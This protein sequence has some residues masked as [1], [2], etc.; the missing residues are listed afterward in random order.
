MPPPKAKQTRRKRSGPWF[1]SPPP[2]WPL[3]DLNVLREVDGDTAV[4]LLLALYN[5]RLLADSP[6]ELRGNLFRAPAEVTINE[7][8]P[9]RLR[10]P[11]RLFSQL[12]R[13]PTRVRDR[14]M[15]AA[16]RAV[17]EWAEDHSHRVT[18]I[19]FA[20]AAARLLP[21]D[22]ELANLAGR[23][24]RR[25]GDRPRAELWY[26]RGWGLARKSGDI[27]QY[28]DGHLG[29]GGLLRDFGEY[30]RALKKIKRAGLSARKKGMRESA[31]EALHD[32][33]YLAYLREDLS[34]AAS[35]AL[36]A[37]KVY[38]IHARRRPYYTADL[39]LL[40]TR[41]GLYAEALDLLRLALTHLHAP[42][43][44]LH[45]FALIA[46]AAGGARDYDAFALALREVQDSAS[47]HPE[48]G[49]AAL[50][51]AAAGA[52]LMEDWT[53][54][55]SLISESIERTRGDVTASALAERVAADIAVR[56]PGIGR[57]A[58][59]EAFVPALLGIVPE[60][61]ARLRR[62]RGATWRPPRR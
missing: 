21:E 1:V 31:A 19:G 40:L 12:V 7:S 45:V 34:R 48:V 56:R 38:P 51:Y 17:A 22:A 24:C 11:L 16:C 26:E 2:N 33:W 53:L 15:A 52:H 23:A 41:R 18:A 62:W 37:S 32:A 6:P 59:D 20:E 8:A 60:A 47:R 25:A 29:L 55:D 44:R 49:G 57:P 54:A 9:D 50:A 36:R 5:V 28:V 4:D 3:S 14:D 39:A 30:S 58:D 27:K 43:E 13:E 42:V 35:L 46:Y 10:D 61:A